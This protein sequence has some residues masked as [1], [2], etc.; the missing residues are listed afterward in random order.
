MAACAAM[1]EL[2]VDV[3][4]EP[5]KIKWAG[6]GGKVRPGLARGWERSANIPCAGGTRFSHVPKAR[7][8]HRACGARGE[9]RA[10]TRWTLLPGRAG[11]S[12]ARQILPRG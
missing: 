5:P 12:G 6:P 7:S 8:F 9:R 4:N 10:K 11:W 2:W 1:T 3:G